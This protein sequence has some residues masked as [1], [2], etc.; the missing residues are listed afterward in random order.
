MRIVRLFGE[1][2]CRDDRA[3]QIL[4]AGMLTAHRQHR[5]V[6]TRRLRCAWPVDAPAAGMAEAV[7][8]VCCEA[9]HVDIKCRVHAAARFVARRSTVARSNRYVVILSPTFT[10]SGA[11]ARAPFVVRRLTVEMSHPRISAASR[12][13]MSGW[14]AVVGVAFIPSSCTGLCSHVKMF[15]HKSVHSSDSARCF[16][17]DSHRVRW[18]DHI[19]R[20]ARQVGVPQRL[21]S[22]SEVAGGGKEPGRVS[23]PQF[24]GGVV[25]APRPQVSADSH[26]HSFRCALLADDAP[27]T[28]LAERR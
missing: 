10:D 20:D 27:L 4:V 15:R 24:V 19:P 5:T 11:W 2:A 18:C 12:L 1:A 6:S 25:R 3:P 22:G 28:G 21:S 13:E 16:G 7:E 8:V 23:C 14:L 9:Q 17:A 26:R